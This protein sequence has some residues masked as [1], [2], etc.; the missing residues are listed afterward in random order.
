[1]KLY[2][3]NIGEILTVHTCT[4]VKLF[5][6]RAR[7]LYTFHFAHKAVFH[8]AFSVIPFPWFIRN[9]TILPS[10]CIVWFRFMPCCKDCRRSISPSKMTLWLFIIVANPKIFAFI[11]SVCIIQHKVIFFLTFHWCQMSRSPGCWQT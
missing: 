5:L 9:Y 7:K 4:Y 8:T 2:I 3:W 1:M 11:N 10:P 6:C